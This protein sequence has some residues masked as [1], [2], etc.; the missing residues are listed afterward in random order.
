MCEGPPE[1]ALKQLPGRSNGAAFSLAGRKVGRQGTLA[2][3]PYPFCLGPKAEQDRSRP[4]DPLLARVVHLG[5]LRQGRWRQQRTRLGCVHFSE[6]PDFEHSSQ[7]ALPR[8][9]APAR[10]SSVPPVV[11][12]GMNGSKRYQTWTAEED[13]K[14]LR[15]VADGQSP[16]RIARALRRSRS[17][18]YNRSRILKRKTTATSAEARS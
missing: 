13:E 1:R 3:G 14:L 17:S 6:F 16:D 10:N 12:G 11:E 18:V 15:M 2:R 7:R 5:Q 9:P 4:C 8:L